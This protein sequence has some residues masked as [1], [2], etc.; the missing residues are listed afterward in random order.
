MPADKNT[1]LLRLDAARIDHAC[2][3]LANRDPHLGSVYTRLGPPPLWERPPGFAT[4]IYIILEQ[5]V[6]LASAKAAFERLK[7]AAAPLTPHTFLKLGDAELKTVGFSRQKTS[8]GRRLAH[9]MLDGQLDLA[10][11]ERLPDEVVRKTL[12][13]LKGIGVWSANIY[14]L[15]VL[16]RP[17]VWPRGDVALLSAYQHLTG[18]PERPDDDTLE[19]TAAVWQPWRSVAARLLWHYYLSDPQVRRRK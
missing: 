9:A 5:Q 7:A 15:M 6:S 12:T 10:A 18:L 16:L 3:E 4:L 1:P 14:L 17:D 11:L 2:R 19:A 13:G 8:Y